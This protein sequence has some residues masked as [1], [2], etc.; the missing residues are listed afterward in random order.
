MPIMLS[1]AAQ[2]VVNV[3]DTAFLGRLGE[4][5]LGA[6]AI[7]GLIYISIYMLGFGFASGAQILMS[8]RNGEKRYAEIGGI[9]NHGFYTLLVFGLLVLGFV[10]VFI[11][12]FL[13][14]FIESDQI[15]EGCYEF[16][17]YRIWG[18]LF[19]F[20]NVNFRSFFV[21]V[22]KT[23]SLGYS[24]A[25]MAVSNV[26]LDYC[27][28]FGHFGFPAMG[29]AGAAIASVIAE[30]IA[31][32]YF[33]LYT[34]FTVNTGKYHLFRF[35]KIHFKII[36]STLNLSVW[37]MLQNFFSLGGWLIFFMIIEKTGE[38]NLAVSNIVRSIYMVL[39]IPIWAYATSVNS[40]VSNS[41]GQ[42]GPKHVMLII[43]KVTFLNAGVL[44]VFAGIAALFPYYFLRIYTSDPVLIEACK[45]TFYLVCGVMVPFAVSVTLFQGL[46]GTGN[47]SIA[48][49]IELFTIIL[50]L[51]YTWLM[52][53]LNQPIQII[54]TAE[55]LYFSILGLL[56]LYYLKSGRWKSKSI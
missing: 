18:I 37:V 4:V 56:S 14:Q 52:V 39:M 3:T 24:S 20:A 19:A 32:V 10:L 5:E 49:A 53:H 15:R 42:N 11:R 45:S 54:W 27:L 38:R 44:F 28:I 16:M 50:Y 2:N 9:A 34:L 36:L 40:L 31:T 12:P 25:I 43:K 55:F 48:M 23:R 30:A 8:R 6:S 47:T 1:L 33:V 35:R 17:R 26:V 7:G 22:T 46:S 51:I 29:I 41:I 21:A 13:N